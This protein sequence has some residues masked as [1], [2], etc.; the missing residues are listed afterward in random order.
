LR[1]STLKLLVPASAVYVF[2]LI[3]LRSIIPEKITPSVT[4][5][6]LPLIILA[7]IL[8]SDLSNRA[9]V[10]AKNPTPLRPRRVRARDVQFLS[11]QVE[12]ASQSSGDYFE[13]ILL[14]RL[15]GLIVEKVSLE[16]GIDK[17][18]VKGE[19]ENSRLGPT[20]IGGELHGLL[21]GSLPRRGVARVRMLQEAID[22]IEAWKA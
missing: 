21:Y 22:G 19:L 16:T 6:A 9:I 11:K 12:V 7:L 1:R 3:F 18:K 4:L 10:S 13:T 17:E 8:V 15:R 14:G 20:L 2:F 5:L